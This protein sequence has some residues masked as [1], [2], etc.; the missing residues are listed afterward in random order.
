MDT[1]NP[2]VPFIQYLQGQFSLPTLFLPRVMWLT[3]VSAC[4]RPFPLSLS[5]P[6]WHLHQLTVRNETCVIT[7]A[8]AGFISG[9]PPCNL[10]IDIVIIY[11]YTCTCIPSIDTDFFYPLI[12]GCLP[13]L[14]TN[15]EIILLYIQNGIA[16]QPCFLNRAI[17]PLPCRD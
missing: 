12:M 16:P 8:L 17:S 5:I 13:I 3:L 7:S 11:D 14:M 9:S 10:C 6:G 4:Y 1:P 15:P 2:S